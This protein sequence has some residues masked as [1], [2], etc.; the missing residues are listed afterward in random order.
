MTH[1]QS[2]LAVAADAG[3]A[4]QHQERNEYAEGEAEGPGGAE[5]PLSTWWRW[6]NARSNEKD[7][8]NSRTAMIDIAIATTPKSTASASARG[9]AC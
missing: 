6:I 3:T 4:Q 1:L 8:S 2:R 7:L 5:M 9:S